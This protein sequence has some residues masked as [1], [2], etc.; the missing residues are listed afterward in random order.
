MSISNN[1]LFLLICLSN[2]AI[3]SFCKMLHSEVFRGTAFSSSLLPADNGTDRLYSLLSL[4]GYFLERFSL[5]L[6]RFISSL[7]FC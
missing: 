2:S 3:Y 5:F 4:L 6:L 7:I 1:T